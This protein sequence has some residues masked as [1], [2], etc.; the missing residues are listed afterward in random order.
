[1]GWRVGIL[2][3]SE[4]RKDVR[5]SGLNPA[6]DFNIYWLLIMLPFISIEESMAYIYEW[7]YSIESLA[8]FKK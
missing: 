3:T 2:E 8:K 4:I 7:V 6:T 1:M 5:N